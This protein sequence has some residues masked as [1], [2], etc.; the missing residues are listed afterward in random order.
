M[1]LLKSKAT[2]LRKA[3]LVDKS[4]EMST[5]RAAREVLPPEEP[6]D[7]QTNPS[8]AIGKLP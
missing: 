1:D 8:E 4:L 6:D 5:V 3:S 2:I 7:L